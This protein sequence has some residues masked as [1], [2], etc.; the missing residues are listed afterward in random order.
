MSLKTLLLSGALALAPAIATA[1]M[2]VDDAYARAASPV[3]RSGAAFLVIT[4][5]SDSDDRVIDA[6][7]D[8]AERVELHTHIDAGNGVMQ[9]RHVPEG[10]PVA[11]GDTRV[12]MRGGDHIMLMG[13]RQPLN[14]GD[15]IEVTLT[16][17][18]AD[19]ITI[20][21]P[22]DLERQDHAGP[23]AHGTDG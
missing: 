15:E 18:H 8:I 6:A 4:N 23:M 20:M 1:Q 10:F 21:I 12:L 11:A 5:T 17:E 22:V 16:F 14:H 13:L 19:P 2:T 7:S 9:M 3:A